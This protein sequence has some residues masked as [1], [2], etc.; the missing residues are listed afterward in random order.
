MKHRSALAQM[1]VE[2]V[3]GDLSQHRFSD[4]GCQCLSSRQEQSR[5]RSTR[6]GLT[7]FPACLDSHLVI[8]YLPTLYPPNS[9]LWRQSLQARQRR[10]AGPSGF[11]RSSTV[12]YFGVMG[13]RLVEGAH[14]R[15]VRRSDG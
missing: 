1:T 2:T 15:E 5:H 7:S 13:P 14:P 8:R 4:A 12:L 3:R 10:V 9:T 6:K 11:T